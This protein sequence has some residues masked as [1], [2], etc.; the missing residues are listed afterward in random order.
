MSSNA[1]FVTAALAI[2]FTAGCA[3]VTT[4]NNEERVMNDLRHSVETS[5]P[6]TNHNDLARRLSIPPAR[7]QAITIGADA[8]V[9]LLNQ[10]KGA[11]LG[12]MC[13]ETACT[14][15]GDADC[16]DM[17]S[18]VCNNPRTDGVCVETGAGGV[19]CSC[20]FTD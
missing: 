13:T 6:I 9:R 16:N 2:L 4:E 12:Y 20:Q 17:F 15:S 7:V 10:L 5:S 18:T 3:K 19:T 14:C 8:K 11:T 1:V